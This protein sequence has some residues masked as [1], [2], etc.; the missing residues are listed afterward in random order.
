MRLDNETTTYQQHPFKVH[1]WA[2]ISKRGATCV[3]IF[4]GIMAD[5]CTYL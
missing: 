2:G 5:T 1:T 4:E 3:C